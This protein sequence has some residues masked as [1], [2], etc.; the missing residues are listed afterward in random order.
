MSSFD[1]TL[2]L[3]FKDIFELTSDP[4]IV[5]DTQNSV[6]AW[7]VA[8]EELYGRS[9]DEMLGRSLSELFGNT[10]L[11]DV[12]ALEQLQRDGIWHGELQ[13]AHCDGSQRLI[14]VRQKLYRNADGEP[15]AIVSTHRQLSLARDEKLDKFAHE[16][17]NVMAPIM[18]SSAILERSI[19]DKKSKLML[20]RIEK[21]ALHGTDL[22]AQMLASEK[23]CSRD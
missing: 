4:V 8:A 16:M 9:A 15:V 5:H 6:L 1:P 17:N 14:H 12:L 23:S 10:D 18:L 2:P 20:Q 19:V 7:N 22:I 13:H 3:T 21:C 11:N